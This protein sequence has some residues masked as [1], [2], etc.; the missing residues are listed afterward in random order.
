METTD[1]TTFKKASGS[2]FAL[3]LG[4]LVLPAAPAAADSDGSYGYV[5]AIEGSATLIPTGSSDRDSAELNQPVLAGDR[6]IV[7]GRSRME[8]VL[9]DRNILRLDG[10]SELILERLAA[11]P[12]SNDRATVLRLLEGNLQLVVLTDSLGDELPRIET[13]NA[14]IY[15]QHYGVYRVTADREGWSEVTVRKG[16]AEVVTERGAV[17]VRADEMALIEGEERLADVDVR[18]ADTYDNLERWGSRMD[19]EYASAGDLDYVD[20]DL[21]Y[22]AA[23]LSRHGSWISYENRHY[24]RPRVDTGWRPYTQ[25]RWV[26]TPSGSTWVSSEPWGWVPYHYG[27]WDYLPGYGWAWEPGYVYSPAWVYWYWG[28][29]HVG[30]CPTGYYTR[31]YGSRFGS[32]FGFRFGV[33]GWAGGDWGYFDRWTF[34]GSD[35]FRSGY[36]R[37]YRDGYRDGRYDGRHDDWDVRRHAVPIDQLRRAAHDMPR[38]IVTTDTRQITP[39]RARNTQDVLRTLRD[40]RTGRGGGDLPDV[41]SFVARRP[42]LGD[43]LRRQLVA[44]RNDE[45]RLNGTPLRPDTMGQRTGRPSRETLGGALNGR[46]GNDRSADPGK[47]RVVFGDDDRRRPDTR[48]SRTD[49]GDSAVNSKPNN[50]PETGS[51]VRDNGPRTGR[52]S[53]GTDGGSPRPEV[54]D[55]AR[56]GSGDAGS[57]RPDRPERPTLEVRPRSRPDSDGDR[58]RPSTPSARP[59]SDEERRPSARPEVRERPETPR[60]RPSAREREDGDDSRSRSVERPSERPERPRVE[61]EER[62]DRG[63]ERSR[64]QARPDPPSYQSSRP[65]TRSLP[66]RPTVRERDVE[67]ERPS[68]TPSRDREVSR[69]SVTPRSSERSSDRPSYTPRSSERSSDRPSARSSSPSS[70]P[71]ESSRPSSSSSSRSRSRSNGRDRN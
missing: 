24:W 6:L 59:D 1:M 70:R 46:D 8:L 11:S 45:G 29:S 9:A 56:R 42:E 71:R 13:P 19:D 40:Q 23:P 2:L 14:T 5:R 16:K 69:P 50:R 61:R 68:Y 15:T 30:W 3:A 63:A 65:E 12:D 44:D 67:R 48:G 21:R 34:V 43:D 53:A 36:R 57:P 52:P 58:P 7:P 60:E 41:S 31:Y 64:P 4:L 20:E 17:Q 25:G 33:Y 66:D 54:L 27:S 22:A 32:G 51:S 55:R 49:A 38:G 62:P 35:Y 10:G 26:Y 37:G 28:P 18:A 47:P 39:D